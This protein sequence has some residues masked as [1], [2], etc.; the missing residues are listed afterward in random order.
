MLSSLRSLTGVVSRQWW[1]QR[2]VW[3]KF[4]RDGEDRKCR[5]LLPKLEEEMET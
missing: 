2:I 4:K 1:E 5:Q 3:G